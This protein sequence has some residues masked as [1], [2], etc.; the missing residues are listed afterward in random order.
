MSKGIKLIGSRALLFGLTAVLSIFAV[1]VQSRELTPIPEELVYC[2]VC[3]GVMLQGNS[4]NEAPGLAG[5]PAWY[6]ESQ[7][8][9]F[10]KGWRGTDERDIS[11]AEM[12]PVALELKDHQLTEI[13]EVVA[14][15]QGADFEESMPSK[16]LSKGASVYKV[17]AS[18][19]GN[20]AQG[21][22]AIKAPPLTVQGGW[23]IKKQLYNFKKGLRGFHSDDIQGKLMA[24]SIATLS[25]EDIEAVSN[26]IISLK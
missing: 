7:L 24:A 23:Y 22:A 16:D 2:T 17:C 4:S 5:L 15:L 1:S 21:I 3:H 13:A 18:C 8:R 11:G 26:Y 10:A 6:V 14:N 9:S 20:D 12:Y 25:D 19:H